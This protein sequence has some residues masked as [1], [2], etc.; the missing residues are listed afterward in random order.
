MIQKSHR[1]GRLANVGI[2]VALVESTKPVPVPF[3]L[4]PKGTVLEGL[5]S[6][7]WAFVFLGVRPR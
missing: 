1:S 4:T 2:P 5:A 3:P 6:P 7:R